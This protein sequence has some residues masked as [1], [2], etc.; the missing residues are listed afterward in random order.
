MKNRV[1]IIVL[2][3]LISFNSNAQNN[4]SIKRISSC[5]KHASSQLNIIDCNNVTYLEDTFYVSVNNNIISNTIYYNDSTSMI[6]P[7][8]CLVLDDTSLISVSYF[9]GFF[10]TGNNCHIFTHLTQNST[11]DTLDFD[12]EI[13]L[14]SSNFANNTF[15][16]G[17]LVL[18]DLNSTCT[19][20]I[21]II[22]ENGF[23]NSVES[24]INL[25]RKLIKTIDFLGREIKPKPSTPF[26]EIYNDGGTEKK[27]VLE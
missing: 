3:L 19:N 4:F 14:S 12:F 15:I 11:R 24:P 7:S 9:T 21:T 2:I 5:S 1:N 18:F 27:I 13:T 25:N 23:L 17:N 22:L 8:H 20:P 10:P 26:I 6:Y 16:N